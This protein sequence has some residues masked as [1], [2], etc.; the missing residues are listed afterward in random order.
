MIIHQ[1]NHNK[2]CLYHNKNSF[3]SPI[4]NMFLKNK[5]FMITLKKTKLSHGHSMLFYCNENTALYGSNE[6]L[7]DTKPK[8]AFEKLQNI[9]T[10]KKH[11]FV[12]IHKKNNLAD[13]IKMINRKN[14]KQNI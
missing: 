10:V 7:Q 2:N 14:F 3:W 11:D 6:N 12:L 5:S 4:I 9:L 1:V 13:F 8:E